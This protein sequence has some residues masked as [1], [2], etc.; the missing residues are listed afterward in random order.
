[1]N[2]IEFLNNLKN[3]SDKQRNTWIDILCNCIGGDT[4]IYDVMN[5]NKISRSTLFRLISMQGQGFLV[6][7]KLCK[8]S[9]KKNNIVLEDYIVVKESKPKTEPKP[10]SEKVIDEVE[11]IISYL[12]YATGKSFSHKT[13]SSVSFINARIKEGY[14]V[15]DFKKVIDI[16]CLKWIN[17]EF[18][19]Y[20][21]PQT[22]F[23]NKMEGYLNE[24][25]IVKKDKVDKANDTISKAK[26]FNWE[27]SN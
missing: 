13:K 8:I 20:L 9:I 26:Q 22:L 18:E 3:L 21:R 7:G 12:N 2:I 5:R 10:K 6:K 15:D 1:M 23:S 16:K 24:T 25:V 19:G 14:K 11:Q 17:T 27:S 4:N